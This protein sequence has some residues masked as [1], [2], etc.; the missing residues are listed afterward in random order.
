MTVLLFSA[1]MTVV[2]MVNANLMAHVSAMMGI[3]ALVAL[4]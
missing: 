3:Q 2:Y 1:S 4:S